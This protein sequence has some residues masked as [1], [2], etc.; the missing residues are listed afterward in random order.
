MPVWRPGGAVHQINPVIVVHA[1]QVKQ[2]RSGCKEWPEFFTK[3]RLFVP[4][5]VEATRGE[6]YER[7]RVGTPSCLQR[8]VADTQFTRL[9]RA[10]AAGGLR[11]RGGE[12]HARTG[13]MP[14]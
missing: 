2:H 5:A 1:V 3:H 13:G 12:R 14:E 7:V 9:M 11:V 6:R 4:V 10:V 8:Q